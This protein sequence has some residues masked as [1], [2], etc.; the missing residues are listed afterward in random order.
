[1]TSL[2]L[3]A[4]SESDQERVA[5]LLDEPGTVAVQALDTPGGP[6]LM[7]IREAVP[8]SDV[9]TGNFSRWRD[10]ADKRYQERK[11]S[12]ANPF[13][14]PPVEHWAGNR[15]LWWQLL[16]VCGW[17]RGVVEFPEIGAWRC[18]RL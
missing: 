16:A 17:F 14:A 4:L 1:M 2:P 8:L 13:G 15:Y 11:R 9:F 5:E 12:R 3:E 18:P 7:A 10:A 6:L